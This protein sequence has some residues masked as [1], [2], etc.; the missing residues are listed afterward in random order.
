MEAAQ[1]LINWLQMLV[2]YE[3]FFFQKE[4]ERGEEGE[5]VRQKEKTSWEQR[6]QANKLK[7]SQSTNNFFDSE[8]LPL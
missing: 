7:E 4:R 6:T 1:N 3:G 2:S 5:R 8:V